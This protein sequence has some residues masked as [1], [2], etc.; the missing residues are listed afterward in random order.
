[1]AYMV[2]R[3]LF[4]RGCLVHVLADDVASHLL[5]EL[6]RVSMAAGLITLCSSNDD[7]DLARARVT[8]PGDSFIEVD[9]QELPPDDYAAADYV[10]RALEERGFI[11][12]HERFAGGDG[13]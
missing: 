10:C 1:V 5:P 13:I 2:E 11:R 3:L 8:L 9:P 6:A 4:D 12:K 7:E